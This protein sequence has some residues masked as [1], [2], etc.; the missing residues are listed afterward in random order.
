[1]TSPSFENTERY[2]SRVYYRNFDAIRLLAASSVIFSYAFLIAT[3]ADTTDPLKSTGYTTA[4]YG[5][6]ILFI[7]S[8][9][10]VTESAR[11]SATLG[12]FI[13]KRF[14]RIMPA[15][16]VSTLV[17]TYGICPLFDQSGW[18]EF[19]K[20]PS[21][22][23]EVLQVITLHSKDLHFANVAFYL[24]SYANDMLPGTA[25]SVLWTIR[26]GV[27][28][29][30][31]IGLMALAGLFNPRRWFALLLVLLLAVG[32][33]SLIWI[34][35][36]SPPWLGELLFILPALVCGIFMNLLVRYHKPRIWLALLLLMG[37]VPAVQYGVLAQAFPFLVA[38][39]LIWLG[40]LRLPLLT[41]GY[42]GTDISYGVY[43]YGWP[44]TQVMRGFMGPGLSGYELTLYALPLTLLVAW[45]SWRLVEKPALRFKNGFPALRL[46]AGYTAEQASG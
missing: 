12:D 4:V 29:Y 41:R 21:V 37:I 25:S 38:Y 32:G 9:F 43:L 18:W 22:L 20:S 36:I 28:G 30:L 1:M 5:I 11:R 10:W 26:L 24:S 40:S 31:F 27:M 46:G 2:E 34:Y 45:L 6:F 19:V 15:L 16:V 17:I 3:G 14:L 35:A 33:A 13:R 8:G 39:P 44:L 23:S 42:T 7:L